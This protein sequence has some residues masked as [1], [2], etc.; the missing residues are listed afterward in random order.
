MD[1]ESA[2][3]LIRNNVR[4]QGGHFRRCSWECSALS[5]IAN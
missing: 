3:E 2:I 5:T 1:L 4:T